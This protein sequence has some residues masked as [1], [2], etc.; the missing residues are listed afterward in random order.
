MN[1]LEYFKYTKCV[2]FGRFGVDSTYYDYDTKSCLEDSILGNL[3]IPVIY[4]ADI[5]HRAPTLTII[6][7]SI[8]NVSVFDGKGKISFTLK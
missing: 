5:S 2:L 3:N 8:A 1:E 6:N 7:G 4:D